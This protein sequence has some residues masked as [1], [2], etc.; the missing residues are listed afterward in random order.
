MHLNDHDYIGFGISELAR[1]IAN[2]SIRAVDVC[3]HFLSRIEKLN[4]Q[5]NAFSDVIAESALREAEAVDAQVAAGERPGPLGGIPLGLKDLIDVTPARCS[6]GLPFLRDYRPQGDA[7]VT[8]RLREA[9]GVVLGVVQTDPGAFDVRTLACTHPRY[10][11]RVVGGSSGGSGAAV[12]AGFSMATLGS[13][14]GGSIRIPAACCG[15]TGFKPTYGRVSVDGVRPLAWSLDHIGPLARSVDDVAAVQ[16]V[17]DPLLDAEPAHRGSPVVGIDNTYFDDAQPDVKE[18]VQK[19]LE[20]VQ[21]L[22]WEIRKV[23]LPSPE[24]VMSF[25]M[26]NLASEAAAYHFEA[27]FAPLEDY[28]DTAR[29]TLIMASRQKGYEYVNAQRRR[30]EATALVNAA[31]ASVDVLVLPTL[32]VAPPRRD[33][34]FFMLGAKRV[35]TLLTLIRYTALFD[36]TGNP[37]L[38]LPIP[39]AQQGPPLSI[40]VVGRHHMDR[41]L[42]VWAK[43]LENKFAGI[44]D[45]CLA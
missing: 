27:N 26:I 13:D 14:T 43:Q 34:D 28:P 9:G 37:A 29:E 21:E 41:S 1:E 17:I 8:R 18:A 36:Q 24:T 45:C 10:P 11:E 19:A 25:H 40:Q 16:R 39:A 44:R 22:G 12:A 3:A 4:A 42:L 38:C 31:F 5:V 30:A 33:A 20:A 7:E 23:S 6:A 2:G 35:S 15:V 32:P